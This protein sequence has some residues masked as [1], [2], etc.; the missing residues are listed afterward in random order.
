MHT[1]KDIEIQQQ[2]FYEDVL[3]YIPS[4]IVVFDKDHRHLFVNST[5]VPD[6]TLRK[7]LIGK[8]VEDYFLLKGKGMDDARQRQTFFRELLHTKKQV[9]WEEELV[10]GKGEKEIHLRNMFPV[11]DERNNIKMVIGYGINITGRKKIEEQIQRSEKRYRDL[12]NYSQAL[13]CTHDLDG[14]IL[15]VNPAIQHALQ[16]TEQELTG[17]NIKELLPMEQQSLFG[18]NYLDIITKNGRSQ[19]VF[20][21]INKSGKKLYLLYQNYKLE[22]DGLEPYIIG[23][24]QDITQRILTERELLQTKQVTEQAYKAK[25]IFLANMSH[26]IRTPMNGI[27]GIAG[28]MEKTVLNEQ[29]RSFLKLIQD[30]AANL[31]VIVND[32][33]DLEK[34][35]AGKIQLEEIPFN[36]PEKIEAAIHSF[37]YKAEEKGIR[38]TYINYLPADLHV[39]GDP[40]RLNQ[41]LNNFLGNAVK[42]TEKGF[43]AMTTRVK[44]DKE[45]W[46][47]IEFLVEDSGIG[48][49]KDK[50]PLIFDPFVQ[51]NTDTTRKYGG[52]GLGLPISKNLIEMQGG[53]L[54]VESEVNKGTVFRFILPYK[55]C[56]LVILEN[57]PQ[58]KD[59][60][61]SLGKRR[62]LVAED[63]ELNQFLAKHIMESWGFEVVIAE[64]GRKALEALE[65]GPFDFILMDIQ[66]PEMDGIQATVAIR[67]MQDPARAAIPIIAI[68]AN[69]LKGDSEKYLH[70][71]MSDYLSK[72]F[73]EAQLFK[74]IRE[75]LQPHAPKNQD[76][77]GHTLQEATAAGACEKLYDLSM[78][79]AVSGGDE[80]F[81]RK[82][83]I[84][85]IDTVPPALDELKKAAEQMQWDRA[86]K[87]AHKLK[88]TIDSMGIGSLKETIRTIESNGKQSR[89]TESI[90]PLVYNL[91]LVIRNCILEL[92]ADF[93]L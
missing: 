93:G 41:V 58:Q 10:N 34:I 69:V 5:A 22:E 18:K 39:T 77:P 60:Y 14:K 85:F 16:Y 86:G 11:L 61:S 52:T 50:L 43:V 8:T 35:E 59:N 62:A 56:E 54:W 20:S 25:E 63:V 88:S 75:N 76:C 19:G 91:S 7:W 73:T 17:R 3:N 89:D 38:L 49:P 87:L 64:N 53:E 74:V 13:I 65:K 26:E 51:A 28:L 44:F 68:T 81:I 9:S 78:V 67:K 82:M 2:R 57:K 37:A 32:I 15:S 23:F 79:H 47:A 71:G 1:D 27:L 48:I 33:L 36:V 80:N 66:M 6:P 21:A 72:P 55:K 45:D 70:A 40:Y 4:D 30:S 42:F 12:F 90:L 29:Q 83:V 24:S 84:L 31:L 92:E 46:A